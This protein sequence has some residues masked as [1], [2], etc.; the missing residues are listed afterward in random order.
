MKLI[1][2]IFTCLLFVVISVH[3]GAVAS[4]PKTIVTKSEVKIMVYQPQNETLKGNKLA[5]RA[6]VS[7]RIKPTD[8]PIFG[9]FWFEAKLLTNRDTRMATLENLKIKE[10]KLPG[11]E[12]TVKIAQFRKLLETEAPKWE[13]E[14]SMDDLLATIEQANSGSSVELNNDLTKILYV[15]SPS[16]LVLIDGEP[17]LQQDDQLKMQRVI[18]TPFLI[19]QSTEDKKYY[20]SGG[21][22]WYVSS[23][24][25]EGWAQAIKLPSSIQQVDKQIKE[26]EK[27]STPKETEPTTPRAIM[28]FTEPAELIQSSGEADFATI[29]GTSLLYMTNS[30]D[31]I[32]MDINQQKYFVLLSGR[33]YSASALKGSWSSIP[34]DKLPSDFQKI[35]EGSAKDNVLASVAGTDASKEAV[36]DAQIPQ[37]A[38]VDKTTATCTVKYDGEPKFEKIE[39]TS[40]LLAMNTSSTVLQS[41]KKYFCVEN[42]VW[43]EATATTGPWKVSEARPA[44]V[45]KIPANSPAYNTQ[46]VYIYDTTPQYVY[47]GYT[48][49]YM[50]CYVYGGVVVYGTGYYYNPWYGPYYY[51][52]PVT[53]G[54][55]MHYNPYTGWSM[56][57]HYSTG[58]FHVHVH[59]GYWG[60]P[61]YRPPYHPPHHGGYYGRNNNNHYG[62]VNINIDRSNNIYNGQKGVAT[63]DVKRGITNAKNQ[64][65][66][67]DIQ[68]KNKPTQKP[69]T[70]DK[71]GPKNDVL[72]DKQ[73]NVYQKKED[74]N[75]Q[76]RNNN[77]WQNTNR[78][79]QSSANQ[80]DKEQQ[81]RDRGN[82]RNDNFN[83][84]NRGGNMGGNTRQGGGG[85]R[86]R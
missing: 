50:G 3:A 67:N 12:D 28:V 2:K 34:A 30:E 24:V 16:T 75:W 32:F 8:E 85:G 68:A 47:V 27:E 76:Q 48:P 33:W 23:S 84:T 36:M 66:T 55:S 54:Y 10:V 82:T 44:D 63:N 22:Y 18:N 58:Y 17:K 42:G 73:G 15:T 72:T 61:A 57:F 29:Q 38:K 5:G 11:V 37:T 35:P 46:Y 81:Q 7:V 6:A 52:R 86:K 60:P 41:G 40:L 74:G 51:P 43:F 83:Q 59:G 71:Q 20:L 62:D 4:W 19:L 49:G 13:L 80:L 26:Q 78:D 39:G 79:K 69:S 77:E 70:Q 31:D 9:A 56:G 25:K 1:S 65:K 14:I 21:K 53:Y 45:E 64:P